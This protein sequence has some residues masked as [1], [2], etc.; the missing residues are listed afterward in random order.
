MLNQNLENILQFSQKLRKKI[1]QF[2]EIFV[3]YYGEEEREKIEKKF[4]S[5]LFCGY[6]TDHDFNYAINKEEQ[7]ETDRI[8][9]NIMAQSNI[10]VSKD[11]LFGSSSLSYS[12]SMPIYKYENFYNSC[13][14]GE[15][16]RKLEFCKAKYKAIPIFSESMS[17]AEYLDIVN[18][19]KI[20]SSLE[21]KPDAF[22]QTLINY[23]DIADYISDYEA[24]KMRIVSFLK[25]IYPDITVQNIETRINDL[26]EINDI[27]KK[28]QSAKDEYQKYLEANKKYYDI[29]NYNSELKENVNNKYL[30]LYLEK[31]K[32]LISPSLK[33]PS[34]DNASLDFNEIGGKLDDNTALID[35][36][37]SISS[38]KLNDSKTNDFER[39]AIKKAR[40]KYFNC[41][42]YNLGD[43]Y[44]D[45]LGID[46]LIPNPIDVDKLIEERLKTELAI[47]NEYYSNMIPEKSF[48]K[49]LAEANYLNPLSLSRA[50]INKS[51]RTCVSPAIVKTFSGYDLEAVVSIKYD[52]FNPNIIDHN[53]VHELNHLYEFTLRDV[54]D[55]SY[56]AIS[57]W[58]I[59]N[60]RFDL[61]E[62]DSNRRQYEL[63]NEIIN[64]RITKEIC[65]MMQD[66]NI[67]FFGDVNKKNSNNITAYDATNYLIN[68]FFNTYRKEIFAS[69]K[70]NNMQC[71]FEAV[72]KEN[73]DELNELFSM[74]MRSF[75]SISYYKMLNDLKNNLD[76]ELTRSF[77][78]IVLR[79]DDILRKMQEHY[80]NRHTH[81]K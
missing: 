51:E 35:Y 69:R 17:F 55:K 66:A 30:P 19:K 1:G 47:S 71:I 29:R 16:E 65:T 31:V 72:G 32:N 61:S 64:E 73:F 79:R 2:T 68:D 41:C 36:F 20:P 43:N 15:E 26:T 57:G 24:S 56:R 70:D 46:G 75:D 27:L 7:N 9:N 33:N 63:F 42:G 21:D 5:A 62:G 76:T 48:S 59:I 78:E 80:E 50:D 22:K 38:N 54:D 40:I 14:L 4:N 45:Y 74:H 3:A 34:K 18:L 81:T 39:D 37:S 58:D 67:N 25:P 77:K 12:S 23:A 53:I 49:E 13:I 6:F 8:L 10:S 11:Y 60:E 28:F 52:V 44:E